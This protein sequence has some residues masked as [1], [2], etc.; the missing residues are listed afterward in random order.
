MD[1]GKRWRC[2]LCLLMI[3]ATIHG[4]SSMVGLFV[5]AADSTTLKIDLPPYQVQTANQVDRIS[6]QGS[7]PYFAKEGRPLV[8]CLIHRIDIPS[9]Q[10]IQNVLLK[11]RS[12][13][14]RATGLRLPVVVLQ[15][16]PD[17]PVVMLPGWYPAETHQWQVELNADGSSILVIRIF[18]FFT[19]PE[20]L[21][22]IYYQQYV[23]ELETVQSSVELTGLTV[24]RSLYAAGDPVQIEVNV[25]N[26]AASQDILIHFTVKKIDSGD[27]IDTLSPGFLKD[28]HGRASYQTVWT[29]TQATGDYRL[30]AALTDMN[31]S[32]LDSMFRYLI[33]RDAEE[34]LKAISPA[35]VSASPTPGAA[36][37]PAISGQPPSNDRASLSSGTLIGIAAG[38][39]VVIVL[40]FSLVRNRKK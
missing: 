16:Y 24:D 31:G 13:E 4:T 25:N 37:S 35:A 6:F 11:E 26:P 33:I 12:G 10:R 5:H 7:E 34:I 39:A 8:P 21:E 3:L 40:V 22:A 20:T 17:S 32:L 28:L 2:L 36:P 18:P 38:L 14:T 19:N 15:E 9:G 29:R 30:E 23:F 27:V 1:N